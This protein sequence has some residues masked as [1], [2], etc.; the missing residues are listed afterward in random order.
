MTDK[1]ANASAKVRIGNA[2]K[3]ALLSG[4]GS[5]KCMGATV[6]SAMSAYGTKRTVASAKLRS[7][8]DP[9]QTTGNGAQ[10]LVWLWKLIF[11][12]RIWRLKTLAHCGAQ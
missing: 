1:A 10:L 12:E 8:S 7:A 9:K 5:A 3:A 11:R 4:F 2:I 6:A